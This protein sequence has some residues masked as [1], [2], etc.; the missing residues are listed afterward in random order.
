MQALCSSDAISGISDR[1]EYYRQKAALLIRA[2]GGVQKFKSI[3][4]R[5]Y[6]LT[7]EE[8]ERIVQMHK[9]GVSVHQIQLETGRSREAVCRVIN[10]KKQ[11]FSH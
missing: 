7:K 3:A 5:S 11:W 2:Q 10:G 4:P 9:D 6:Y 8:R 1:L